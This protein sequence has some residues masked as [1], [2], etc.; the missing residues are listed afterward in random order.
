[1]ISLGFGHPLPLPLAILGVISLISTPICAVL[2]VREALRPH[3]NQE[4]QEIASMPARE[5]HT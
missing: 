2:Y 4:C 5:K 3:D 1:M